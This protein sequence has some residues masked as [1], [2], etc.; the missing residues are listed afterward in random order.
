VHRPRDRFAGRCVSAFTETL[1]RTRFL[2]VVGSTIR[3]ISPEDLLARIA[4][5]TL[6]LA[7]GIPVTSKH[8]SYFL[9]LDKLVD[10]SQLEA[11]WADHRKDRHPA[12]FAAA[13]SLLRELIPE[14]PEL[15][16]TPPIRPMRPSRIVPASIST[17]SFRLADL[18]L[19]LAILRPLL[20]A[21][22]NLF[23]FPA[24]G[25]FVD[26]LVEIPDLPR[27]RVLDVFHAIA[28]DYA[29]NEARIGIQLSLGKKCLQRRLSL[30]EL[31]QLS[32]IKAC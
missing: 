10:A 12:S 29:A 19:V 17:A 21:A 14:H 20:A 13:R 31:S 18:N 8:A 7:G 28:T 23:H 11:A 16:L 30:D 3:V 26:Q 15:L 27:Q 6:D 24:L 2:S 22:Q 25:Q 9:R 1:R 5:L 32:V 4:R